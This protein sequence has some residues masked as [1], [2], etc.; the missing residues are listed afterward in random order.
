MEREIRRSREEV[1]EIVR[2]VWRGREGEEER[3]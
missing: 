3:R 1:R 2:E